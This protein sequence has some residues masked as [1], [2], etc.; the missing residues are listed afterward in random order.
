[1]QRFQLQVRPHRVAWRWCSSAVGMHEQAR[2]LP[3]AVGLE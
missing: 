3:V 2:H 1:V